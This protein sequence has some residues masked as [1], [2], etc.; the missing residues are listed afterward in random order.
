VS[1]LAGYEALVA[2]IEAVDSTKT[3]VAIGR[4]WQL[5]AVRE[6]KLL[7]P[8]KTGNLGRTIHAGEADAFG[9]SVIA[10]AAYARWVE[11]GTRA[12]IIRPVRAS[13]LAW[14]GARRLSGTLR[15]GS[16]PESFA[17]SVNHPGTRAQPYL[18][19]GAIIA[20]KHEDLAEEYVLAWNAAA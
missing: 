9:A 18:R 15:A 4:R 3:L 17:R 1:G 12:H 20:L 19:P 6:A 11:E 5:R 16:A 7:V 13:A 8:R 2:R 14:G 10:S